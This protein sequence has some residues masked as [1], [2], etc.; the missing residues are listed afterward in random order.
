MINKD[1]RKSL[2]RKNGN[3]ILIWIWNNPYALIGNI[4]KKSILAIFIK[5][6]LFRP[7]FPPE[8]PECVTLIF[9]LILKFIQKIDNRIL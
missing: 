8:Q 4:N 2:A 9:L 5:K 7:W 1:V 3:E 6:S